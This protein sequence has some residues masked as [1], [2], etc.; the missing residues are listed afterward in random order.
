MDESGVDYAVVVWRDETGWTVGRVP[1]PQADSIPTLVEY[2]RRRQGLSGCLAIVAVAEEFFVVVR[3][4]GQR[5]RVLLSDAV[6]ALDWTIAEE[7]AE[8]LGLD[9]DELEDID[10]VEPAGDLTLLTDLGVA[11]AELDDLCSDEDLYPD[12]QIAVIAER[13]GFATELADVLDAASA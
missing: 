3:V 4:Q 5:V 7:A 6:A 12:E 2:A 9:L 1:Q 10:D 11:T 13:M 8:L